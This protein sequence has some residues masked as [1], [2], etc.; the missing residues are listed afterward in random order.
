M[1]ALP[2][3]NSCDSIFNNGSHKTKTRLTS[4]LQQREISRYLITLGIFFKPYLLHSR[5]TLFVPFFRRM[6]QR[7]GSMAEWLNTLERPRTASSSSSSNTNTTTGDDNNRYIYISYVL[8]TLA[9]RFMLLIQRA[10][11]CLL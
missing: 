10:F 3:K 2:K 1:T 6:S 4:V 7:D 9:S 8:K 11:Y 5:V